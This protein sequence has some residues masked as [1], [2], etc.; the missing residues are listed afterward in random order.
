MIK[1]KPKCVAEHVAPVIVQFA[2]PE[3]TDDDIASLAKFGL[4]PKIMVVGMK[5]GQTR[6][7]TES[8]IGKMF[9]IRF[10]SSEKKN[11]STVT[12]SRNV[13]RV[14]MFTGFISHKTK[15]EISKGKKEQE[16]ENGVGITPVNGF[17]SSLKRVMAEY[18]FSCVYRSLGIKPQQLLAMIRDGDRGGQDGPGGSGNKGGKLDNGSRSGGKGGPGGP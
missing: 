6:H 2:P 18:Y 10:E 7:I 8:N 15:N 3:L 12:N 17:I 14:F 1:K 5:D 13:Q 4:K 9:D 16:F 11:R